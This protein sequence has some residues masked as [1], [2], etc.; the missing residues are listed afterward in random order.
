MS[1]DGRLP[2]STLVAL[3]PT[4]ANSDLTTIDCDFGEGTRVSLRVEAT[5]PPDA[6]YVALSDVRFWGL[7]PPSGLPAPPQQQR[8]DD[9]DGRPGTEWRGSCG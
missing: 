8:V 1:P 5:S 2:T 4:E 9:I 3:H 7:V 6:N